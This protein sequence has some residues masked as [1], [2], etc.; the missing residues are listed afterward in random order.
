VTLTSHDFFQKLDQ[1]EKL[2]QQQAEGKQLEINQLEK[3]KAEDK[4]IQEIEDL[5]LD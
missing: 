4:I 1:I 3:I 2:K 5:R